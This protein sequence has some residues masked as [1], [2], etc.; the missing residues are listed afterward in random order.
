VGR[1]LDRANLLAGN[2][3][4][5]AATIGWVAAIGANSPAIFAFLPPQTYDTIYADGPDVIQAGSL[6]PRGQAVSVPGG[7][8]FTGQWPFASGC[9]HAHYLLFAAFVERSDRT[10]VSERPESRFGVMP[11]DQ[12]E[13]VDTWHVSGLR[14]TAS[15][16][17]RATNLFVPTEWTGSLL[18]PAPIIRHPLDRVR[19]LGRLGLELAAVAVGTAQAAIDDLMAVATTKKPLGGLLRRLAEEPV[20][21][22]TLGRLDKEVRAARILLHDVATT[23][24]ERATTG[25]DLDQRTLLERRTVLSRVGEIAASVVDQS[26]HQG[27]T[28]GLFEISP[29][30]RRLRDVHAVVQHITFTADAFTPAGATLLGEPTSGVL[31]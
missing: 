25:Q 3:A 4:A 15:H 18:A 1:T 9:D 30:Q 12:V 8:C 23:D 28:T 2:I 19:P 7:Y 22:H 14:G 11:A 20:F 31:F 24:Y 21:Q 13:I 16:D 27:G 17:L 5:E 29:L 6:V 26:Y 10:S